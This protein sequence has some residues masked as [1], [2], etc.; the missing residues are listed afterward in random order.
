M[1]R[2]DI[3]AAYRRLGPILYRRCAA[4]LG[5][6]DE[7]RDATQEAFVRLVRFARTLDDPE[8]VVAWL[9]RV[10]TNVC[11]SR[12]RVRHRLKYLPPE[13]LPDD[14]DPL[15]HEQRL[16]LRQHLERA[17]S[18][19]DE[20]GQQVFVYAFVDDLVQ[21]EIARVMGVSRRTVGK[22][23][24]RVRALLAEASSDREVADEMA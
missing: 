21:E 24:K 23:I 9:Y 7:A 16:I 15:S 6:A 17:L 12:L 20:R 4:L 22:K 3:E 11:L 13:A 19:L 1:E 18:E 5:D 2:A 10:S 14:A 8:H